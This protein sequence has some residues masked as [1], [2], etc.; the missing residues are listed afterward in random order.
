MGVALASC[1]SSRR[2]ARSAQGAARSAV[3]AVFWRSRCV[4]RSALRIELTPPGVE[5][6]PPGWSAPPPGWSAPGGVAP[7]GGGQRS[8]LGVGAEV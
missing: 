2:R 7:R 3:R 6:P 8:G 5:P 1:S 4:C